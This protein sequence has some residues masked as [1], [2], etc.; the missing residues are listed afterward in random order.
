[1]NAR[2][3]SS[4]A[5]FP[6]C[7]IV[8]PHRAPRPLPNGVLVKCFDTALGKVNDTNPLSGTHQELQNKMSR[9]SMTTY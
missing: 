2:R 1:M 7:S 9:H 6:T 5:L 8:S 3:C 4:Q